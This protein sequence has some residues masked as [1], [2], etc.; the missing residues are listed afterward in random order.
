M[1][2]IAAVV[3]TYNRCEMLRECVSGLLAQRNAACDIIVVDNA[4]TDNTAEI[5]KA[6]TDPRVHYARMEKNIGGAGGFNFGMR[7]A[8]EKGYDWVWVMDDDTCP[9]PDALRALLDAGNMLHKDIGF[10]VSCAMWT[11]GTGCIMNKPVVHSEYQTDMQLIEKGLVRVE[12]ATFVSMLLPAATIRRA[13]LPIADFFIWGDDVEYSRRIAVRMNMPAYL[14]GASKVIHKM[15]ENTGSNLY[16]DAPERISRYKLAF[17]NECY[18]YSRE[19]WRGKK[20]YVIRI[21]ANLK[22]VLLKSRSH[23]LRRLGAIVGGVCAGI[24]FRP[25]VEYVDENA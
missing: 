15:K 17:R 22:N 2:R 14:V 13:G 4:S 25:K 11:D 5:V 3:V 8:V 21:I 6:M 18:L 7:M 10:L 20:Y 23:R 9:E 16:M 12:Q 24:M 19:G 1:E